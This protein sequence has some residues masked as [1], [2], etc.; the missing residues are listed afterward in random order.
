MSVYEDMEE[1]TLS[2][3]IEESELKRDF[4]TLVDICT[5]GCSKEDFE[6]SI[7]EEGVDA[8]LRLSSGLDMDKLNALQQARVCDMIPMALTK[9][10]E[11]AAI[12]EVLFGL[13]RNLSKT[14]EGSNDDMRSSLG[15]NAGAM[16]ACMNEHAEG[17]ATL[18]EMA[19]LAI[20]A[21]CTGHEANI[22]QFKSVD[23]PKCLNDVS[24]PAITNERNMTYPDKALKAMNL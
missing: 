15:Q 4:K 3:L 12:I 8:L 20:E 7:M 6:A 19:C 23:A 5:C 1:D 11:E 22:E 10:Q 14:V 13:I 16:I 21:L 18:Q 24:R 17:E 2:D 9:Y